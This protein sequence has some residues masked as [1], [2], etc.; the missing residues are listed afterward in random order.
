M[1][2]F[3]RKTVFASAALLAASAAWAEP[4]SDPGGRVSFETPRSWVMDVRSTSPSTAVIAG[5]ANNE[6]FVF[7][8]PNPNT[9][10]VSPDRL[11]RAN[12]PITP[13]AWATTANSIRSMFP[14]QNASVTSQSVDT[15]G[16]W[17]IQRAE[18]AGGAR[19]VL[20]G[21]TSRPGIDL[22]AFCWT[23]AGSDAT[24]TYE[25]LFRSLSHP[26]DAEWRASAE[27]Q[28]AERAARATPAPAPAPAPAPN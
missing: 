26:S 19:P 24:A 18:L 20:A 12:T 2:G 25:A 14:N 11:H 1:R 9:A 10:G 5:N 28:E 13:E 6:C 4:W 7:A 8:T 15:T 22:M 17:P 23:Y 16:F 27:Q 21:L 3:V